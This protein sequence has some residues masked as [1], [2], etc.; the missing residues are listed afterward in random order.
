MNVRLLRRIQKQILKEPKQFDIDTWFAIDSHAPN[1]GTTACIAG[2]AIALSKKQTP[3]VAAKSIRKNFGRPSILLLSWSQAKDIEP[4][5][6]R[7]L[8]LTPAQAERLFHIGGWPDEFVNRHH[9]NR[10]HED[11][12][13]W[14]KHKATVAADRIDHFIATKGAE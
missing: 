8:E 6:R 9:E 13:H 1:C 12:Y 7:A 11:D 14:V 10:D 5:A 3:L 2:W 4:K